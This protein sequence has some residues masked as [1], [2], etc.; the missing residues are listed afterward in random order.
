MSKNIPR[1]TIEKLDST[2]D[3]QIVLREF[4]NK[5]KISDD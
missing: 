4:T 5:N 2:D 3:N 1:M